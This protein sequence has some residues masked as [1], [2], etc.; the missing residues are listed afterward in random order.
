MGGLNALRE[1]IVDAPE[2]LGERK[3][4]RRWEWFLEAFPESGLCP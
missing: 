3:R 1:R 4:A 2:S